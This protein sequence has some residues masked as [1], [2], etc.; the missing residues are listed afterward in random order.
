M[1]TRPARCWR[2][3][4]A[5][6]RTPTSTASSTA[7][8]RPPRR[9]RA[10]RSPTSSARGSARCSWWGSGS[11]FFQQ[12]VG[13]N[14][15]IYY[16]PTI[17]QQTGLGAASA[18]T[19]AL[20]VGATNVV[21]TIVAVLLLDRVGRRPLLL[22]GTA[23]L[24][25][26]LALLAVYFGVPGL[27]QS[28]PWLALIALVTYIAGFAIGL[29]PV[30]WLMISEIFPQ[31]LRSK[32][33]SVATVG[34]WGANLLISV[35][36]LTLTNVITRSGTFA[37]YTAIAIG[38][39]AFFA[40]KVPETNGRTLED[41]QTELAPETAGQGEGGHSGREADSDRGSGGDRE[42]AHTG[43]RPGRSASR[44]Y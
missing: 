20:A 10:P 38:A 22:T 40:F 7:S 18:I 12:F 16:A 2:S 30:F 32:A 33:M 21:F 14:T 13:V 3:C 24:T 11:R 36:F 25:V 26:S 41:I 44:R 9:P 29:G 37:L 23:V 42:P 5:A 27:Q 31:G 43:A 35:T 19:Q 15:V 6:W 17:L 8:A 4:V 39:I 1:R 34:N 28:V